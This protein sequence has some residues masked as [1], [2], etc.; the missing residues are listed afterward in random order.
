MKSNNSNIKATKTAKKSYRGRAKIKKA[1]ASY[2]KM[3]EEIKPFIKQ[4]KI[5]QYSTAGQW[6]VLNHET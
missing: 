5:S 1:E 6:K 4:R 2:K 3:I